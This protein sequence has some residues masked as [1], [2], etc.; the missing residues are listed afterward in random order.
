VT[1][2]PEIL[3]QAREDTQYR[4]VLN[5]A[6]LSVPDGVGIR[7]VEALHGEMGTFRMAG[8]DIGEMLLDMAYVAHLPVLFLG[9]HNGA[10]TSAADRITKARTNLKIFAAGDDAEFGDDGKVLDAAEA[11][12]I[13]AALLQT[14]PAIVLVGLGAPKQ[15]H[16]IY[17]NRDAFPSVKVLIGVGGA[18]DIWSGRLRRAPKW[19]RALGLEWFWRLLLEPQRLPRIFRAVVVFP[20]YALLQKYA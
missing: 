8:I 3:L 19:M 16:W 7:L 15:E 5:A 17:A 10:A 2:N 1:P 14:K 13:E 4:D 11:K 12:R 20:F 18:F 6:D 9:G